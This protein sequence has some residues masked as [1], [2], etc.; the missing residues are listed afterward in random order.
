MKPQLKILTS[1]AVNMRPVIVDGTIL[2]PWSLSSVSRQIVEASWLRPER[3]L[4]VELL[5]R[6]LDE[7]NLRAN[8]RTL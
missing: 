7:R 8:G 4:D 6:I 5:D 2:W 1:R 3:P